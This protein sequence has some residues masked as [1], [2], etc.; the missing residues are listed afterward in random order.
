MI[1][2]TDLQDRYKFLL[3]INELTTAKDLL[4]EG[5]KSRNIWSILNTT[6]SRISLERSIVDICCFIDEDLETANNDKVFRER[7][8]QAT[9]RIFSEM[10]ITTFSNILIEEALMTPLLKSRINWLQKKIF[11]A[12]EKLNPAKEKL[13]CAIVTR[14]APENNSV[15]KRLALALKCANVKQ[16]LTKEDFNTTSQIYDVISKSDNYEQIQ[17]LRILPYHILIPIL[18]HM[19]ESFSLDRFVEVIFK[20]NQEQ[21]RQIIISFDSNEIPR[22]KTLFKNAN[23]EEKT[24]IR[25]H[26]FQKLISEQDYS[27]NVIR[28]GID[29]LID[30]F[31]Y[32]YL[33]PADFDEM[34]DLKAKVEIYQIFLIKLEEL[35]D[36]FMEIRDREI[37][38]SLKGRYE[39]FNCRL[40]K[41]AAAEKMDNNLYTILAIH[42]FNP[43]YE[44]FDDLRSTPSSDNDLT[45]PHRR[46]ESPDFRKRERQKK[47]YTLEDS[48]AELIMEGWNIQDRYEYIRIGLL[49]KMSD[50]VLEDFQIIKHNIECGLGLRTVK[51]LKER[52]I[53]SKEY[54]KRY[55]EI[56]NYQTPSAAAAASAN[57]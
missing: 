43:P 26:F 23:K 50:D 13:T 33:L 20:L 21:F 40:T 5:S 36:H 37:L 39:R 4:P 6:P 32:S 15:E 54:L 44:E 1:G 41:G 38:T 30:K 25:I 9:H 16:Q 2:L 8:F 24:L 46:I 7:F 14:H 57:N 17:L 19:S 51:D 47:S 45:D 34:L 52:D 55:I 49:D 28:H 53:Y 10:K 48:A 22:L 18:N 12:Q 3:D 31:H 35:M 27:N 56:M 11:L 42:A 29:E